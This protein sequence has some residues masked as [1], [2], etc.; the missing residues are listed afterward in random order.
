[1]IDG[2]TNL[3]MIG[4][5][6]RQ[7]GKSLMVM[8]EAVFDCITTPSDTWV[9][10]STTER[11]SAELLAKGKKWAEA[12]LTCSTDDTR[13]HMRYTSSASEIKFANGSRIISVPATQNSRGWTGNVILDEYALH[14]D[15]GFNVWQS[16][17]AI[18]TNRIAGRKKLRV[19][20]TPS[21]RNTKFYDLWT[22]NK[23]FHKS[24]MTYPMCLE[25]GLPGS[26]EDV[27]AGMDDPAMYAIEFL[28]QFADSS[29]SA[30]PLDLLC[31]QTRNCPVGIVSGTRYVGW[32]VARSG[33]K[34]VVLT[35]I[36]H[37][38]SLY[39]E[40]IQIMRDTPYDIQKKVL[41]TA[42]SKASK[43]LIDSS[44]MG[45]P[46]AEEMILKLGPKVEKYQFT[47]QSKTSLMVGLRKSLDTGELW[48]PDRKDV[49]DDIASMDKVVTP[50][51]A[52][53]YSARHTKSGHA[54]ICCALALAVK[55]A[56]KPVNSA[57][58]ADIARSS[59]LGMPYRRGSRI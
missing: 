19:I 28:C 40:D 46:L 37:D 32:D 45:D 17:F 10:L 1:M 39:V 24:L 27:L 33:D 35:L 58:P 26:E 50:T 4:L 53:A 55:A 59:R 38:D 9:C 20:S 57:M 21:S 8:A 11:Q 44:G 31:R 25:Q 23:A 43:V 18:C 47:A 14:R 6:A 36:R 3:W 52:V 22:N 30:F 34:S 51:G 2:K 29:S 56:S 16:A 48:I 41:A 7:V 12:F 13:E 5:M 54:D 15:G 49:I 42:A